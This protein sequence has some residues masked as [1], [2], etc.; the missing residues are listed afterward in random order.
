MP[1]NELIGML[2]RLDEFCVL[3]MGMELADDRGS[4]SADQ[5]LELEALQREQDKLVERSR[6]LRDAM[7]SAAPARR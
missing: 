3:L 7:P 1:M 4:L 2:E 6:A 5:Q